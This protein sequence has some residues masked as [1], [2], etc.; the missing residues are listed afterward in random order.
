MASRVGKILVC[1]PIVHDRQQ[2]QVTQGHPRIWE[3]CVSFRSHLVQILHYRLYFLF[4][5]WENALLCI[6]IQ[7]A[8]TIQG[9]GSI[10]PC[11]LWAS[12]SYLRSGIKP[13]NIKRASLLMALEL[14]CNVKI[15]IKN[16][17]PILWLGFGI[18][19]YGQT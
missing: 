13:L 12:C 9:G 18:S 5:S 3:Q 1:N 11:F 17:Y 16:P 19:F 8:T 4:F 6:H 7:N 10:W 15:S 2:N 14:K